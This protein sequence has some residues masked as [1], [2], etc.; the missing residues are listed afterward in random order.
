MSRNLPEISPS[1]NA[2]VSVKERKRGS[3]GLDNR[4]SGTV[5]VRLD[6]ELRTDRQVPLLRAEIRPQRCGCDEIRCETTY[7]QQ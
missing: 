1:T 5:Y 2:V 3:G 6:V 7:P 4:E